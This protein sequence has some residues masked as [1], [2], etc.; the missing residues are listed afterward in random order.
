[1]E[2]ERSRVYTRI[3]ALAKTDNHFRMS[4]GDHLSFPRQILLSANAN[5][6]GIYV[7]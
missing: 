1:M 2:Q 4:N 7:L 3:A 6:L 5:L